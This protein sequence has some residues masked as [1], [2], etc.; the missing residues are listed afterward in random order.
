MSREK[1]PVLCALVVFLPAPDFQHS[2]ADNGAVPRCAWERGSWAHSDY[3]LLGGRIA[4]VVKHVKVT[5]LKKKQKTKTKQQ[6]QQQ[7]ENKP[8]SDF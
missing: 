2:A 4:P 3:C 5:A 8:T 6:N 1:K 7:Q